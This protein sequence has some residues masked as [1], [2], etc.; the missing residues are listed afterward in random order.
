MRRR[1]LEEERRLHEQEALQPCMPALFSI[2][3]NAKRALRSKKGFVY[4]HFIM[5]EH[6][7]PLGEWLKVRRPEVGV[8]RMAICVLNLLDG[9]HSRGMVHGSIHPGHIVRVLHAGQWR[10]LGLGDASAIGTVLSV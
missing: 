8:L 2:E 9:M 1:D 10:L 4:P 6:G 3:Y 7:E 5:L